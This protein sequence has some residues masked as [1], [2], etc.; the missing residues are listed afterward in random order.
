MLTASIA[1]LDYAANY[2]ED[3]LYNR[4]QPEQPYDGARWTLPFQMDVR[5]VT[6][7]EPLGASVREALRAVSSEATAWDAQLA[8]ASTFDSPLGVGF[9]SHPVAAGIVPPAGTIT[10]SGSALALDPAQNNT[11]RALNRAWTLGGTVRMDT[12]A[13]GLYWV[14][15][16]SGAQAQTLVDDLALKVTRDSATGSPLR[17]PRVGLY[18]PWNASMDEGWTRWLLERYDF[19]FHSL[20]RSGVHAGDLRDRYDVIVLPA[21]RP[22]SLKDGHAAGAVPDYYGRGLGDV[23]IRALETFVRTGALSSP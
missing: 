11:F 16:L 18:R 14:S 8:D 17:R 5:V 15:G 1:T 19:D 23:G 10:G 6:A 21:E 7:T 22:G 2:R 9:D 13:G 4:Y 3:L 12:S 20:R